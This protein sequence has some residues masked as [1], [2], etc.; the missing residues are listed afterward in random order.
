MTFE[1]RILAFADRF[2]S[3]RTVQLIVEPALADLQ[4]DRGTAPLSRAMNRLAV[5]KAV[6]G[7][8]ADEITRGSAGF[9]ALALMPTCYDLFLMLICLDFRPSS[10]GLFFTVA[11]VILVLSLGPV[12][13]CF[14][15]ARRAA[16]P[17][18]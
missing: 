17:V 14:W 6:G 5:L 3:A 13:V 7:G 16:R 12:M 1:S 4:F 15:P 8:L 11:S 9:V 2:L 18:D 10:T